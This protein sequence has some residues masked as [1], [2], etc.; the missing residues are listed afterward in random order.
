MALIMY[1]YLNFLTILL[2]DD[3]VVPKLRRLYPV[4]LR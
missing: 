2:I 3:R 1:D 4:G